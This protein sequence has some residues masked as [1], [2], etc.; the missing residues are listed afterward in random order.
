MEP[1]QAFYLLQYVSFSDDPLIKGSGKGLALIIL[2]MLMP[3]ELRGRNMKL[4]VFILFT[5]GKCFYSF[6][7]DTIYFAR[8]YVSTHSGSSNNNVLY[9][10]I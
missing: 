5:K 10:V 1:I 4:F 9:E 3:S 7:N 8:Q 2:S 6:Y